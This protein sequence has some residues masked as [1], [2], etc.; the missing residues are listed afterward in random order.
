MSFVR[1]LHPPSRRRDQGWGRPMKGN[2]LN[3]Y[4]ILLNNIYFNKIKHL[5][6]GLTLGYH[7]PMAWIIPSPACHRDTP[8]KKVKRSKSHFK[9]LA[10]ICLAPRGWVQK[11]QEVKKSGWSKSLVH[12]PAKQNRTLFR[13]PM[14]EL[15]QSNGCIRPTEVCCGD[16]WLHNICAKLD[17]QHPSYRN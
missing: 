1:F 12:S 14:R 6:L 11:E 4:I 15:G 3:K 16:P 17:G 5:S 9:L 8:C 13:R 2:S 10:G 7:W